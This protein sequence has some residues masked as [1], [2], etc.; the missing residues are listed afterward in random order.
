[1]HE[2]I[3]HFDDAVIGSSP[4]MLIH[5]LELCRSGRRVVL[6]ERNPR[7]GG[8]WQTAVVEG[9]GAAESTFETEIACHVI[10]AFPQVYGVLARAAGVP[11]VRLDR[12]PIRIHPTGLRVPYFSRVLLAV[13][14][15]RM[16]LV[17]GMLAV[18][19][20][21]GRLDD[22]NRLIN[23]RTK[24]RSFLRYQTP[25]LGRKEL[26]EGPRDGFVDYL[27]KLVARTRAEGVVPRTL[28]VT[29]LDRDGASWRVTGA[30]GATLAATR[31][32]VTTSTNLRPA[33]T[34]SYRAA[35]LQEVRRRALVVCVA[36]P[37][38][39]ENQ[40][41]VA[42]WKDPDVARIS[43]IDVPG[44]AQEDDVRFLVEFHAA[45]QD[46]YAKM[47]RA[48]CAQARMVRAR[49]VSVPQD[50]RILGQVDCMEVRNVDQLPNGRI[51]DGLFGYHSS[52]NLAAGVA[53]WLAGHPGR[54]QTQGEASAWLK[55]G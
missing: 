46:A 23:F 39:V 5:A 44:G 18:R 50:A 20:A 31:V 55:T 36:R 54:A 4:L 13:S 9:D 10:E 49:I 48:A 53:A 14:G 41:Y 40:T 42:F 16:A 29:G 21:L 22:P 8:A 33:G 12:Q 47:D 43:R 17:Y 7:P 35:P 37:A 51:D 3:E 38:I 15:L 19:R 24:F 28:D 34:G 1:M 27:D 32:H 45:Q 6:L 30:N 25:Y 26:M 2:R 52:G 11:F